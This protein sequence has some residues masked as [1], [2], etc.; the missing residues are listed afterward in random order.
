MAKQ[1]S[2]FADLCMLKIPKDFAQSLGG[3]L[4]KTLSES[5]DVG[6]LSDQER[7]IAQ[8]LMEQNDSHV[9]IR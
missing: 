2:G 3:R 7:E 1:I 5:W 9:Q 6:E 4:A 8:Q